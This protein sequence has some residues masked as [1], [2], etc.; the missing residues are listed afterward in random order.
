MGGVCVHL[1]SLPPSCLATS[2][3]NLLLASVYAHMPPLSFCVYAVLS[4]PILCCAVPQSQIG[5]SY[6]DMTPMKFVAIVIIVA[7][8]VHG[9]QHGTH[10][11]HG[12]R[13]RVRV[14]SVP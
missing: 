11:A 8:W 5:I 2:F 3:F 12:T 7:H 13:H 6:S 14:C 4:Y 1:H 10:N 9:T